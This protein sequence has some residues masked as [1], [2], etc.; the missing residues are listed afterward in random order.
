MEND[1]DKKRTAYGTLVGKP[2]GKKSLGNLG[3]G[4]KIA[5]IWILKG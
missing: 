4:E 2:V 5:L 1:M 3:V